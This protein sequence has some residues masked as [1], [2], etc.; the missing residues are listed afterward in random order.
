MTR[1]AVQRVILLNCTRLAD[2][3]R[4]FVVRADDADAAIGV[5]MRIEAVWRTKCHQRHKERN[6]RILRSLAEPSQHQRTTVDRDPLGVKVPC[7]WSSARAVGVTW[8]LT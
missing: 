3:V 1:K 6:G 8:K 2:S 5:V 7:R 4:R